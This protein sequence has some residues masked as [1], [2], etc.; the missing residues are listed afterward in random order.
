M[1]DAEKNLKDKLTPEVLTALYEYAYDDIPHWDV[2]ELFDDLYELLDV[3][4]PWLDITEEDKLD[5][6]ADYFESINKAFEKERELKQKKINDEKQK[7]TD[8]IQTKFGNFEL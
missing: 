3:R 1:T 7:L 5:R 4:D 8:N 6:A 2:S